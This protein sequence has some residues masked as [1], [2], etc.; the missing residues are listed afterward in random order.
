MKRI[1]T[2]L[3]LALAATARGGELELRP[4]RVTPAV[5]D[6]AW[7]FSLSL[8]AWAPWLQGESGVNGHVSHLDLDPVDIVRHIDFAADVRVEAQKGRFSV[9]GELLYLSLSD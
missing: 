2:I 4:K 3:A 9:R 8:P 5:T 1:L 6:S 7:R